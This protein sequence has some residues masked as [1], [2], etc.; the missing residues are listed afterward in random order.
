[1]TAASRTARFSRHNLA[2]HAVMALMVLFALIA[3]AALGMA[4]HRAPA[5]ADVT[6]APAVAECVVLC[7]GGGGAGTVGTAG[8]GLTIGGSGG[9]VSG[10]GTVGSAGR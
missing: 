3:G 5:K 10:A 1:M 6:P 8:G 4:V 9:V 2:V 7:N